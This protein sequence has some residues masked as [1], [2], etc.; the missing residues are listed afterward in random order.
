MRFALGGTLVLIFV[1]GKDVKMDIMGL[2]PPQRALHMALG[3]TKV[4]QKILSSRFLYPFFLSYQTEYSG[5]N[6]D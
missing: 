3:N 6:R 2:H 5:A 4:Q 1:G